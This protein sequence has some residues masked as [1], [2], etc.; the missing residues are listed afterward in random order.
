[1]P[2]QNQKQIKLED[3]ARALGV[4]RTTISLVIHDHPRIPEKTKEMVWEK[5]R[6]L[7]YRPDKT[8]R[9]LAT[10]RSN[11]IGFIVPDISNTY[12]A[13]IFHGAEETATKHGYHLLVNSGS[14][15]LKLEEERIRDL[16]DLKVGGLITSPAFTQEKQI[17]TPIWK[18]IREQEIPVVLL[19]RRLTPPVIHQISVDNELGVHL[20]MDH[21]ARLGHRR[22]AYISGKPDILPVRQRLKAFKKM[23]PEFGFSLGSD[24]IGSS[25]FTMEGGYES[26][27]ELWARL[28]A[29]P[30]AIMCLNDT[31]ALGVLRF[32]TEQGVRVP[33]DISIIGY[34]GTANS[35]YSHIA[36]TTIESP[37]F[38][39]GM[40][41]VETLLGVIENKTEGVQNIILEPQLVVRESTGPRKS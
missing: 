3:V 30:T 38:E 16:L 15:N 25:P 1:M 27:K 29:K 35:K 12:F 39:I 2:R 34:D 19:N 10:G 28:K 23:Q 40:R 24:L 13:E 36:L 17:E 9:A 37:Q 6:E 22:V 18:E 20:S 14:Y 5:I 32:L 26:C 11:L 41:A 7:G 21:L 8:A 4:T 31:V 33:H